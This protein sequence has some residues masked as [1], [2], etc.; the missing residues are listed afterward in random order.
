[1]SA[2]KRAA[3]TSIRSSA[4]TR[5][6]VRTHASARSWLLAC[7]PHPQIVT[8]AASGARYLAATAV[9]AAVRSRVISMESMSAS[10]RPSE[11]SKMAT[12]P[13]MVGRSWR[14]GIPGKVRV[15]LRREDRLP[16]QFVQQTGRL[17]VKSAVLDPSAEDA[18]RDGLP[19]G[20]PHESA[21]DDMDARRPSAAGPPPPSGKGPGCRAPSDAPASGAIPT[22]PAAMMT[23]GSGTRRT[24][25]ST[26]IVSTAMPTVAASVI[27]RRP[28]TTTAPAIA[29]VAA[30]VTPSTAAFR[31]RLAVTRW[32]TA[33]RAPP[34]GTSAGTRRARRAV[35]PPDRRRDSR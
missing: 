13:W 16:V 33:P 2:A 30:A 27:A 29:P 12:T 14:T 15:D 34:P 17:D 26:S 35:P 20:M 9:A 11:A 7:S 5:L 1:M 25:S 31:C 3:R 19:P 4:M 23:S 22:T 21:L 18:R 32:K 24:R 28:R 10:K 8:V 6:T